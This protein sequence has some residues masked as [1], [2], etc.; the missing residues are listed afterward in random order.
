MSD[1]VQSEPGHFLTIQSMCFDCSAGSGRWSKW[2]TR[3][4]F[5]SLPVFW[6]NPFSSD[7]N[8][9]RT[10]PPL[11]THTPHPQYSSLKDSHCQSIPPTPSCYTYKVNMYRRCIEKVIT[12]VFLCSV[13]K[14]L[15]MNTKMVTTLIKECLWGSASTCCHMSVCIQYVHLITLISTLVIGRWLFLK[16]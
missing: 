2:I 8:S 3:F 14:G 12:K 15:H 5:F 1:I 9:S 10:P 16:E 11:H 13:S 6:R 4:P 7:A